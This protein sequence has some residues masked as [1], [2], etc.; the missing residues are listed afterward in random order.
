MVL[1]SLYSMPQKDFAMERIEEL[2]QSEVL[3]YPEPPALEEFE[4]P[5]SERQT[6]ARE[7][8]RELRKRDPDY[9][10]AFHEK[11]KKKS[12]GRSRRN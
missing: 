8:D 12:S 11:K 6:Q 10:G 1:R 4:T 2:I 5:R 3:P 9:Q 7:I